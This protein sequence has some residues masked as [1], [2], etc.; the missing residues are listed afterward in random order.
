M[1]HSGAARWC[2]ENGIKPGMRIWHFWP[3]L[4]HGG[5]V[6]VGGEWD[7]VTVTGFGRSTV[8]LA[9]KGCGEFATGNEAR[10][11]IPEPRP[12]SA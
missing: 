9:R 7:W 6:A 8:L 4:Q 10:L 1:R 3:N 12:E 5:G 11:A 2:I